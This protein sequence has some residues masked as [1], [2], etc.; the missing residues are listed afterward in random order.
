MKN[1]LINYQNLDSE[2]ITLL[3]QRSPFYSLE[4]IG[5]GT[6]F[7]ESLTGYLER[8][9]EAHCVYP[10]TLIN[11]VLAPIL[12]KKYLLNYSK[13]CGGEGFYK[14]AHILNGFGNSAI[15]FISALESI[16][17]RDDLHYLTLLSWSEVL[18]SRGLLR[19]VK[20]WCPACY[21]EWEKNR[22]PIYEPLIWNIQVVKYCPKHLIPL[23]LHCPYD[24]CK[25]ELPALNRQSRPGY[26]AK[27]KRWLGCDTILHTES[28]EAEKERH[29]VIN[30]NINQ[31]LATSP[32]IISTPKKEHVMVSIITCTNSIFNGNIAAFARYIGVPRNTLWSWYVGKNLPSMDMLL[33]IC[34]YLRINLLDFLTGENLYPA[35]YSGNL[36]QITFQTKKRSHS[37]FKYDKAEEA[38]TENLNNKDQI[39]PVKD[40]A[41]QL[42]VSKRVL[43]N[44]FPELC[45]SI[46]TR[47]IDYLEESKKLRIIQDSIEVKNIIME[48]YDEGIYPS[49]RAVERIASKPAILREKKIQEAWN[50]TLIELGFKLY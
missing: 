1:S 31:L 50:N 45:R 28:S 41:Q 23:M 7:V 33:R 38:L 36:P 46:T 9:S 40:V 12:E 49:R 4:P 21:N 11:K 22:Q 8:L 3:P 42:G 13:E 5:I 2:D 10:G 14:D 18:I 32:S 20:A 25:K 15:E 30:E 34:Y 6:P 37:C 19:K 17:Q 24:D 48:L 26:C 44:H 47:Y 35:L 43:Y 27:C 39:K 16:T 29:T